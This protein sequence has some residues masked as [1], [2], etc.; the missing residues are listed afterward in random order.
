[1]NEITI[2]II[3]GL[4]SFVSAAILTYLGTRTKI[5]L[6]LE[7][8]YDKDLRKARIDPY[9]KLWSSLQP[10]A[11]YSR[12]GPVTL[13]ALS[14]LSVEM[15]RWYFDVGGI[16]LSEKSRPAYFTLQETIRRKIIDPQFQS[17]KDLELDEKTFE[18]V[19][20]KGSE[21]RAALAWDIG[22]RRTPLLSEH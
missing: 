6:D 20:I 7:A 16:Y 18:S 19:R 13:Q 2:P 17:K 8:E 12:P 3:T 1:M 21:L 9:S 4:V 5:R 22:S 10:L 14:D 11:K 15:R